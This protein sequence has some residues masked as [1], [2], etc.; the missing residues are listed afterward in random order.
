MRPNDRPSEEEAVRMVM[1]WVG[2]E[3]GNETRCP[4]G[5]TAERRHRSTAPERGGSIRV[6]SEVNASAVRVGR[7][8]ASAAAVGR[9]LA[10]GAGLRL[11]RRRVGS[12]PILRFC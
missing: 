10:G 8:F 1:R 9:R 12:G 2:G 5:S 7:G 11:V 6:D 4:R 3:G